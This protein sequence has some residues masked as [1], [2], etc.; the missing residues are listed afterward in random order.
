M[1]Q[2]SDS[3]GVQANQLHHTDCGVIIFEYLSQAAAP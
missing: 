3:T 1:A 2:P